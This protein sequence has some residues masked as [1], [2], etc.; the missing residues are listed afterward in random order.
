MG[1]SGTADRPAESML[2]VKRFL[3]FVNEFYRRI[4]DKRGNGPQR[5]EF[6]DFSGPETEF[7]YDRQTKL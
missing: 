1:L 5:E 7:N 6:G 3:N 2:A 4:T